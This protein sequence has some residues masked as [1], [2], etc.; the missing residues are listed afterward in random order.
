MIVAQTPFLM[1][2]YFA[3]AQT[4]KVEWLS[5]SAEM[6]SEAFQTQIQLEHQVFS[7][8]KPKFILAQTEQMHYTISPR[9]QEWHNDLIMPVFQTIGLR[10]LAIVVSRDLFTQ[11]SINQTLENETASTSFKTRHFESLLEAQQWL[12]Q[13]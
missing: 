4:V 5:T 7:T 8:Y 11:V 1:L 2:H 9:E 6:N 13:E 3:D 10:K 12:S